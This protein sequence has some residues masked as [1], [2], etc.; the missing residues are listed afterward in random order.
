MHMAIS[1]GLRSFISAANSSHTKVTLIT[2]FTRVSSGFP[3]DNFQFN[4]QR[5][6]RRGLGNSA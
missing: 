3:F 6:S 5:S 4:Q 2:G 1:S